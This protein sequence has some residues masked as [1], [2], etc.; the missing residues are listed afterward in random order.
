MPPTSKLCRRLWTHLFRYMTVRND[1]IYE[2]PRESKIRTLA[3]NFGKCWPIFKILQRLFHC[4]FSAESDDERILK[5]GQ[6][7]S[8]LYQE[9]SVLF[10]FDSRGSTS[11]SLI[12]I[13]TLMMWCSCRRWKRNETGCSWCATQ[14]STSTNIRS[15]LF[16]S[17]TTST[18]LLRLRQPYFV[19]SW[20]C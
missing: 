16:S 7:F 10:F 17:S 1:Y 18:R 4:T 19:E 14:D 2:L 3:H 6:H 5:V 9:S 15:K 20:F 8:K 11:M 13:T 12:D